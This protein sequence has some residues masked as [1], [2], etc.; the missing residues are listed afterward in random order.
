MPNARLP[1]P[2]QILPGPPRPPQLPIPPMNPNDPRA[3]Q[4]QPQ[5]Q[6]MNPIVNN[7]IS[8]SGIPT[9]FQ[10]LVTTT[11]ANNVNAA[12]TVNSRD[13]RVSRDPRL[14]RNQVLDCVLVSNL[15][16]DVAEWD[17]EEF[18]SNDGPLPN[19]VSI[20]PN[21]KQAI[22]EYTGPEQAEKASVLN[23]RMFNGNRVTIELIGR[24][25]V[26]ELKQVQGGI[27]GIQPS[28]GAVNS[29]NGVQPPSI[30]H[31]HSNNNS[32][33]NDPRAQEFM[34]TDEPPFGVNRMASR[35]PRAERMMENPRDP[36]GGPRMD[37]RFDDIRNGPF[38]NRNP[39]GGNTPMYDD[40][41]RSPM[42][43]GGM[44]GRSPYNDGQNNE[45][46]GRV[47]LI[48]NIPYKATVED[49]LDFFGPEFNLNPSHVMRRF[50]ERGQPAG[51]AKVLF[52]SPQD[53]KMAFTLRKA[54][55]IGGRRVYLKHM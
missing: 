15:P 27:N 33:R 34:D 14:Q 44:P 24:D 21:K 9:T 31:N 51:E 7:G 29:G 6:I 19:S 41:S 30:N 2:A 45:F 48:E 20:L 28:F 10:N 11:A 50:N 36:R 32:H 35:D 8:T 37:P 26:N 53:C 22:C 16:P 13:P 54:N 43:R 1:I 18:M 40:G 39:R 46:A 42:E 12:A 52:H 55:L 25:R 38:M 17:L 5:Q 4:Q 23:N 3:V 47:L 49:I